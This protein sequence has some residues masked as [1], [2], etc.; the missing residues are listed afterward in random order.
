MIAFDLFILND[1]EHI[2]LYG[3]IPTILWISLAQTSTWWYDT[4]F[5]FEFDTRL[6]FENDLKRID[7]YEWI[8]T[9]LLLKHRPGGMTRS[10][11]LCSLLRICKHFELSL[12]GEYQF[13]SFPGSCIDF[14]FFPLDLFTSSSGIQVWSLRLTRKLVH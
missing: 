9:L 1:R 2:D 10:L 3:C 6:G 4:I 7:L 5:D 14:S 11:I 13:R 8:P 12:L